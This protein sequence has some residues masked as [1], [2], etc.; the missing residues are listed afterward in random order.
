MIYVQHNVLK[1]FLFVIWEIVVAEMSRKVNCPD[2][3]DKEF[4]SFPNWPLND[5][6]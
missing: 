6:R 1:I 5:F 3:V 4:E 2:D